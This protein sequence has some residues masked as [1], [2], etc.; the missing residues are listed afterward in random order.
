M[1]VTIALCAFPVRKNG[2]LCYTHIAVT[3]KS[4][5]PMVEPQ[6]WCLLHSKKGILSLLT[7]KYNNDVIS[8]WF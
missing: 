2:C 6:S 3:L 1:I 8:K 7:T 4:L 5:D